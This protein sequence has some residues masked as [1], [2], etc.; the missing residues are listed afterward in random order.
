LGQEIGLQPIS[1]KVEAIKNVVR[2]TTHKELRHFI[3]MVNY[4]R[5]MWVRHSELLAPLISMMSKSVK[6]IWMD[7]RQTAFEN[8]KKIISREVILTFPDFSTPF[9]IYKDAS[10][11]QLGAVITQDD[12]IL[13]DI[14]ENLMVPRR[15]ILE[16]TRTRTRTRTRRRPR[17]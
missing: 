1:T 6:F 10:D 17:T 14:V 7:E 8:I 2:P 15:D 5:D 16:R 4:Q 12:K 11:T 3:G 13:H 9:H